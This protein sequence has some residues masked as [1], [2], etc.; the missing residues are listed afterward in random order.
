MVSTPAG[1]P[2]EH[3]TVLGRPAAV[4]PATATAALRLAFTAPTHL[5]AGTPVQVEIAG[6]PH[7]NAVLVPATA[8]VQEGTESFVFTVDAKGKAHR[9][10]VRV[11]VVAGGA[12]EILGGVAP[13]DTVVVSGQNGLPDG[14]ATTPAP[15]GGAGGES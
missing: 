3:A 11:G 6:P 8:L 15:A 14:A 5:P 4:D 1:F 12:A 13:G 2:P 7:L 10:P 9:Q